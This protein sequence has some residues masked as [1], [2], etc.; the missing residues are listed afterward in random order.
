MNSPRYRVRIAGIEMRNVISIGLRFS[1]RELADSVSLVLADN[2]PIAGGDPIEVDIEGRTVLVGE[3]LN[4][5]LSKSAGERTLSITGYSAS[6][7]LVKSSVVESV[8]VLRNVSLAQIVRRIVEPYGLVADVSE[9]ALEV[10]NEEISAVTAWNGISSAVSVSTGGTAC[11]CIL[12]STCR[13]SG[14]SSQRTT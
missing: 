11:G 12:L 1:M 13:S 7:R 8:R 10:A 5:R 3:V 14:T 6:Q 4:R 9:S 2:V